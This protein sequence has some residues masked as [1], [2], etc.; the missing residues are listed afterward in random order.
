MGPPRLMVGDNSVSHN[1]GLGGDL[2]GHELASGGQGKNQVRSEIGAQFLMVEVSDDLK[3]ANANSVSFGVIGSIDLNAA[4]HWALARGNGRN[5]SFE[6][7]AKV[8]FHGC[9]LDGGTAARADNIVPLVFVLHQGVHANPV[10]NRNY[11]FN[12]SKLRILA[13]AFQ[14]ITL[15]LRDKMSSKS[16]RGVFDVLH[17]HNV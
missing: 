1:K 4:M 6:S 11:H 12:G 13:L 7:A 16:S 8:L 2:E 14:D 9:L 17:Y 10:S 3:T 5:G 15:I